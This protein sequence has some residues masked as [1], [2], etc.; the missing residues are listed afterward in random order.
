MLC[1]CFLFFIMS[2]ITFVVIVENVF[3]KKE[4]TPAPPN[5]ITS[6]VR[7]RACRLRVE[8]YKT[9]L[10]KSTATQGKQL[11]NNGMEGGASKQTGRVGEDAA[12]GRNAES[13]CSVITLNNDGQVLEI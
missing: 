12:A 2:K 8:E 11:P 9:Y 3:L 13:I 1:S 10:P 6:D 5:D 7:Q 4:D